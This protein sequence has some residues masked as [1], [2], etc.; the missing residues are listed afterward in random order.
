MFAQVDPGPCGG[1]CTVRAD[2]TALRLNGG[3]G[4]VCCRWPPAVVNSWNMS[5]TWDQ[6]QS[7]FGKKLEILVQGKPETKVIINV[8][9]LCSDGDCENCCSTNSGAGKWK[10]IDIEKYPASQLLGFDFSSATF[11]INDVVYPTAQSTGYRR[12]GA[13]EDSVIPL[14]YKDLGPACSSATYCL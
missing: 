12:A 14:C 13:P 6:D 9:D 4:E 7:L 11:D 8:R 2:G 3:N 1:P 10:L 5:A